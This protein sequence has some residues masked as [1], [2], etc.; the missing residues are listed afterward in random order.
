MLKLDETELGCAKQNQ[1]EV[2]LWTATTYNNE[3]LEQLARVITGLRQKFGVTAAAIEVKPITYHDVSMFKNIFN[4][5]FVVIII[6][7]NRCSFD[8][9]PSFL[10]L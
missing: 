5:M 2:A 10:F 3:K 9:Y 4:V 7:N 6:V 1:F 8:Y